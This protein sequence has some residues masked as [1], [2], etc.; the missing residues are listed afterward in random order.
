MPVLF[1]N[2]M[3]VSAIHVQ[4]LSR[5]PGFYSGNL[6]KTDAVWY[7]VAAAYAKIVVFSA[8]FLPEL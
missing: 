2:I 3:H 8:W 7:S 5:T 1:I 4:S 6:Q